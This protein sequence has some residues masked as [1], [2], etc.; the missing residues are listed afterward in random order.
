MTEASTPYGAPGAEAPAGPT[1]ASEAP[2]PPALWIPALRDIAVV[3]AALSLFAAADAWYGLTG[4]RLAAVVSVVDGVLVG[5]LVTALIH[6]WGHYAGAR[7]AGAIAPLG[8][9]SSLPLFVFDMEKNEPSQFQAMSVGGNLAHW[10]VF[11]LLFAALPLAT[12]GQVAIVA[13]SFGFAVFASQV[14]FP[15]IRR[16]ADGMKPLESLARIAVPDLKTSLGRKALA[17]AGAGLVL[18]LFL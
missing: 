13:A 7:W 5:A 17:G 11:A 12:P 2:A 3:A 1:P 15:V 18:S 14:E 10:L 8:K 4:L 6:E 9:P 16:V